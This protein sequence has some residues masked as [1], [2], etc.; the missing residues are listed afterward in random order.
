MLTLSD[1]YHEQVPELVKSYINVAN[2][3]GAEPIPNSALMNDTQNLTIPVQPGKTYLLHLANIGAFASQYFWIEGHSMKVVEVD[4]V[5]TEPAETGMVYI[6]AAQRYSVLVTMKNDSSQNYPIVGAMD[7]TLFDASK[8]PPN[9]NT[10]VTSWLLYND[11]A[12]KPS[13]ALLDTYNPIDDF[14]LVPWDGKALLGAADQTITLAV[15]MRNLGN[16]AN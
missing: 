16:G 4:G 6:G 8:M 7:T 11:A 15:S 9:L 13:P 1:W 10:N 2:P 5:W 12:S 14:Y 3:T